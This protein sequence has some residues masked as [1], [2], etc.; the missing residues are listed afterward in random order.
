MK[1]DKSNTGG[2]AQANLE[3]HRK[4]CSVC[5]HPQLQEI[6][7]GWVNWGS[8]TLIAEKYGLSRDSLYRHMHAFGLFVRRQKNRKRFLE[9]IMERLD[10]TSVSGSVV[11]GAFKMY[12]KMAGE[13]EAKE[14][15]PG[16]SP[17]ATE[18][19]LSDR[20]ITVAAGGP[21]PEPPPAMTKDT[22]NEPAAVSSAQK[23]LISDASSQ[24][25]AGDFGI[26]FSATPGP[27]L[28]PCPEGCA[29][30]DPSAGLPPAPV[31]AALGLC[32]EP[33]HTSGDE[34]VSVGD[35]LPE[36]ACPE[37]G[38]GLKDSPN[39]A[40]ASTQEEYAAGGVLPEPSSLALGATLTDSLEGG[41]SS[42]VLENERAV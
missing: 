6:E 25:T 28:A 11:L 13:E 2:G 22:A 41:E 3:L 26:G 38:T 27:A 20:P 21:L 5:R 31:E 9:K 14:E 1:K 19:R 24:P 7:E 37:S 8:T 35:P 10:M 17:A 42:Q 34:Q 32:S 33:D 23:P 29:E 39:M 4:Q 18:R 15:A 30:E 12:L 36:S 40:A 16:A